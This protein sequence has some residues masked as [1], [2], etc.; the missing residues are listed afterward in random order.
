M[1]QA[2]P[3]GKNTTYYRS[4]WDEVYLNN[5]RGEREQEWHLA[6]AVIKPL[7]DPY[8]HNIIA[9]I[10]TK[11]Q[12]IV[13]IG[14]GGS[15]LGVK[16][17]QDYD[18]GSLLLTD[19]SVEIVR[20]VR[21]RHVH[22]ARVNVVAA[23][24]RT[25]PFVPSDS[26]AVVIDKG[27]LDALV[28]DADKKSMLTECGRILHEHGV[29]VSVSFPAVERAKL[30]E[31]W[32]VA[33]GMEMR[34]KVVAY[35]DPAEGHQAMFV[36]I[37]AKDLSSV[38]DPPDEL[39]RSCLNRM[40]KTGSLFAS[41]DD[42]GGMESLFQDNSDDES[43]EVNSEDDV[44]LTFHDSTIYRSDLRLFR[45]GQWLN[46]HAILFC[47][48]YFHFVGVM[49]GSETPLKNDNV[50]FVHPANTMLLQYGDEEDFENLIRSLELKKRELIFIPVN[51]D[52]GGMCDGSHWSVLVYEAQKNRFISFDSM[53]KN[54]ATKGAAISIFKNL[55]SRLYGHQAEF[56]DACAPK[57]TNGYDCGM[58]VI[59]I[60]EF[61]AASFI[62]DQALLVHDKEDTG[63][64]GKLE[65][66]MLSSIT[67]AFVTECRTRWVN[68]VNGLI[69]KK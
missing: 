64:H 37:I 53:G 30:L 59:C 40:A 23:D 66:A 17:L 4:H 49:A 10:G 65:R 47:Y 62:R 34:T 69:H 50:L 7:I 20:V 31:Q 42:V 61:V 15:S 36:F 13:D 25:L 39:T 44:L 6:Y 24:C 68:I 18:F 8:V 21:A 2:H 33:S 54:S 9:V 27:N 51:N 46:D 16:I 58:Y 12:C 45:D 1:S 11:E 38:V 32:C 56:V 55:C 29:F 3:A 63:C 67:P 35:G 48:E 52:T 26:V 43:L 19:L 41:G 28:G 14:C 22:D 60:S 57:Q 5:T